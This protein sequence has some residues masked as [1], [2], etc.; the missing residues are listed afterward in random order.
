MNQ[1]AWEWTVEDTVA[2]PVKNC[3]VTSFMCC[4]DN[5]NTTFLET[6]VSY[7]SS[8][9][10]RAITTFV[11]WNLCLS[12]ILWWR[13]IILIYC[14]T[15]YTISWDLL[16]ASHGLQAEPQ[17]RIHI[18]CI[19]CLSS[20]W[21]NGPMSVCPCWSLGHGLKK[22]DTKKDTFGAWRRLLLGPI[23]TPP[24]SNHY[25]YSHC[26]GLDTRGSVWRSSSFPFGF[27]L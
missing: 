1:L 13:I 17:L 25:L 23:F 20:Q 7:I 19:Y 21:P 9:T 8:L 26:K 4:I 5:E 14:L 18:E 3:V 15:Y 10:T 22:M 24:W 11:G 6:S 12:K 16:W 27:S 2:H